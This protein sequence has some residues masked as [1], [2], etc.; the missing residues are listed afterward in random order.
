MS[1]KYEVHSD[2]KRVLHRSHGK[3][4][5]LNGPAI[6]WFN[7]EMRW[8]QYDVPHRTDG[9]AIVSEIVGNI[10]RIRGKLCR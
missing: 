5:R 1:L 3:I 4:H 9:P 6:V 2:R 8:E 7:G 10:W